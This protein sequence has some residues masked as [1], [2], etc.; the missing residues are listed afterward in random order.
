MILPKLFRVCFVIL[1]AFAASVLPASLAQ[2]GTKE[3]FEKSLD[4]VMA[5]ENGPPGISVQVTRK[6][7]AEYFHRGV[8]NVKS[9][10]A[11]KLNEHFRIASV[12][13]AFS[14]GVA[15]S[16][17]AR[18]KLKLNDT[19]GEILPGLMPKAK[20][21]TL[22]QALHHTGG[23]PDYIK[24]KGFIKVL[25]R[26]PGGYLPPRKLISYVKHKKLTSKPGK[27]YRYSDT[28]NII[29]GLMAE[30]VT[31]IPYTKLLKRQIYKR[32]N[33]KQ[34]SL[35]RTL[36]MPKPFLRGYDVV[37]GEPPADVTKYINP[38]LAWA[39]G[40]MVSSLPD[41]GA[42][43]RGYVPGSLFGNKIRRAQ[44]SWVK[45]SSSPPGPGSNA[46]GLALFRYT[47]KCGT[48]YGHTGSFPGY[49]I[50]AASSADGRAS[51]AYVANAQIVPDLGSKEVSNLIRASQVQAVCHALR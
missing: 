35:P 33:L 10:G 23:L 12:A 32:L 26:N 50:F 16:L 27:K 45:G 8:G 43:F 34:T 14:G 24:D 28:D 39:S 5:A 36:N 40:G 6:G 48:V 25:Q 44:R 42:Y 17:V 47:S 18:G 49:R 20:K 4:A 11:P 31:G 1:A 21:V 22:A 7:K 37:P 46:A 3:N 29:V 2:A 19:I 13:K 30:K 41:L 9:G 51:I 38:A 15:L